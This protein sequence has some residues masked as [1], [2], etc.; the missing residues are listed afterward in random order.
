MAALVQQEEKAGSSASD[1]SKETDIRHMRFNNTTVND[2]P[3]ILW[4]SDD[5]DKYWSIIHGILGCNGNCRLKFSCII[6]GFRKQ[7]QIEKIS[8]KAVNEICNTLEPLFPKDLNTT[9]FRQCSIDLKHAIIGLY[10]QDTFCYHMINNSMMHL[11]EKAL[12]NLRGIIAV[13]RDS[14]DNDSSNFYK[15]KEGDKGYIPKDKLS[16]II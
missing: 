5:H 2:A 8:N 13:L 1:N 15:Y 4:G 9:I 3:V 12:K 11:N 7:C 10:T 16:P 6:P 14:L